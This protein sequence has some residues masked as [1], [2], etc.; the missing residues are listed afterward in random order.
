MRCEDEASRFRAFRDCDREGDVFVPCLS[1]MAM[2]DRNAVEF[3]QQAHVQLC[4][5][6]GLRL[7]DMLTLRGSL[8]RQE[9]CAGVMIDDLILL[10]KTSVT[11]D[12]K[13]VTTAIADALVEAYAS[14]GLEAHEGKRMRELLEAKF[15]GAQVNGTS[16]LV[17]AQLERSVPVAFITSQLCRLGWSH[18]K[19]LE[20]IAGA[21]VSI[22]QYRRRGMSVLENVFHDI[23]DHDYDETFRLRQQTVAE[24]W[25]LVILC[26]LFCTDLR[27]AP[28]RL[29]TMVDAS[30]SWMASVTCEIPEE[31]GKELERHQLT[32][33]TWTKLLSPK[34]ALDR[35]HR[36]LLP[37][38]EVPEGEEPL[39]SHPMWTAL[40]RGLQF[41][42]P[43]RKRIRRRTHINL[44]ELQAALDAERALATEH[45]NQRCAVGS[46]SQVVLGAIVKGRSSSASLNKKLRAS[47]P[48]ILGQNVY[49]FMHYIPTAD[50]PADDP[51]REKEV[52]SPVEALPDWYEEVING[53][54]DKLD[55]WLEFRG[56]GHAELARLPPMP[57]PRP[58]LPEPPSERHQRRL[59]AARTGVKGRDKFVGKPPVAAFSRAEP[60][61]P[62]CK[63]PEKT[64]ALLK[65]FPRDQFL[66]P[67]GKSFEEALTERGHLDLFSGSRGA[68]R[69]LCRRSGRFVLTFD[70]EHSAS[71]DLLDSGLRERIEALIKAGAFL[72][73]TGGPVCA[74]FSRAVRPAVRDRQHAKGLADISDNMKR[75]V[76]QGNSFSEWVCFICRLGDSLQILVW[77]ENPRTSF[78]W[79]QDEWLQLL[80]QGAFGFFLTDYCRWGT[81]WKKSTAFCTNIS[82]LKGKRVLCQ[83]CRKHQQLVGYSRAH[84]KSWTKVAE[85]Y[86]SGLCAYLARALVESLKPT[87]RRRRL[88]VSSCAHC[89][90]RIGEAA[91]PGP[92][93]RRPRAAELVDLEDIRRILPATQALQLRVHTLYAE[94]LADELSPACFAAI[95]RNPHLQPNFLRT[96]GNHLFATG[97]PMY[98]FRHLTVLMQQR[99]PMQLAALSEAWELLKRWE[100]AEPV[101]HRPPLPKIIY[102]AFISLAVCWGW[103]RWAAIT[104]LSFH[105]AMRIGEPLKALR[106][107]LMLPA[108]GGFDTFNCFLLV[109]NPKPRERGRGR[110]QHSRIRDSVAV[111]LA[112]AAFSDLEPGDRLYTGTPAAYRSR[113][114]KLC[115]ALC[116]PASLELTPGCC[117]GGGA[118]F[119]Y[120][121]EV[122][123]TNILWQMRIKQLSTL[124]YYLQETAAINVAQKLPQYSRRLV[125]NFS[126]ILPHVM[127]R[128]SS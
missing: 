14:V 1:T 108:D 75:K 23:S 43:C 119:L 77:V 91:N 33:A 127:R 95:R 124:E 36:R 74:S 118:V 4:L 28:A 120:H 3:G 47:L 24:L 46:D 29:L 32:R 96:F 109:K 86:P 97:K 31:L 72:S 83:C 15:W 111:T 60:W 18:R 40:A 54:F 17:R 85:P 100:I 66:L 103:I 106:E 128:F 78:L 94:W 25:S 114:D 63:L 110:V 44:D 59:E 56:G 68:A 102:D 62:D 115:A 16:G 82:E 55:A 53:K 30:D 65:E 92:R 67:A 39:R 93:P 73:I 12:A 104:A 35:L 57:D 45:P 125:T 13:L 121:Q 37:E 112:V 6:V 42:Q 61:M 64:V 19:L 11:S 9:W 107:D 99:Y 41:G 21:W 88:D 84:G 117:R 76:A 98:L 5:A 26:P 22:L 69:A 126:N 113:W 90:R 80:Q 105:G 10:E 48:T 49:S 52:R 122:P 50:N 20:V 71:E 101:S 2:G 38:D 34:R 116:I 27:A 70:I 89:N 81:I 79:L 58:V 51:T 123:V 8:P 87:D 7:Q